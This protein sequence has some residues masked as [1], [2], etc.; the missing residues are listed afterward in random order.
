MQYCVPDTPNSRNYICAC[1]RVLIPKPGKSAELHKRGILVDEKSDAISR[2]QLAPSLMSAKG[3][4]IS[5]V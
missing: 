5:F 1:C 2:Q 3:T 4:L